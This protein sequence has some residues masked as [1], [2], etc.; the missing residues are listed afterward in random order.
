MASFFKTTLSAWNRFHPTV[1]ATL[2]GLLCAL[3]LAAFGA[4]G[5]AEHLDFHAILMRGLLPFLLFAGALHVDPPGLR[6]EGGFI[7]LLSTGG[8][9]IATL[10]VGFALHLGLGLAGRS[11]PLPACLLF[12]ALIS[13]TDPV[14]VLAIFRRAKVPRA[15]AI[16]VG[17][18][19]L[20]NDGMAV[21][22]FASILGA[23]SGA[24]VSLAH[25]S[26]LF[27]AQTGGGLLFGLL[28]G[29]VLARCVD[30]VDS[31]P[32]QLTTTVALS[33]LGY[34]GANALHISG[35]L[36]VI[37]AGIRVGNRSLRLKASWVRIDGA[38]NIFI[39]AL[40]GFEVLSI[41]WNPA[42]IWVGVIAVPLVL[43]GRALSVAF[44]M[45][46]LR[47]WRTLLPGTFRALTWGGLRGAIPL[48]LALNLPGGPEKS[49][50]LTATYI[51]A[52]FSVLVQGSTL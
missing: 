12:G 11:V 46:A 45:A 24:S 39:F 44:S 17:A 23:A 19:S 37:L 5:L 48:A 7:A 28:L 51:V 6:Q 41:P 50:I 35:L 36:A 27:F 49:L 15:L 29:E 1:A 10:F 40:L 2:G 42:A 3:L 34:A 18:E 4:Q 26:L 33:F 8:V 47:P 31:L 25:A 16:T 30:S 52:L 13:P 20:F 21:V 14:A 22:M 43:A 38:L 32:A 9:I